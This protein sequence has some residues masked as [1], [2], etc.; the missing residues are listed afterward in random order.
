VIGIGLRNGEIASARETGRGGEGREGGGGGDLR[1][2]EGGGREEN[3]R[4]TSV[5]IT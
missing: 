5:Q 1:V 2:G 3:R 4:L